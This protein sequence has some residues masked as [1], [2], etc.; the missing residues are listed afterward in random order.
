MQSIAGNEDTLMAFVSSSMKELVAERKAVK[1]A[2][3][4]IHVRAWLWEEP[5]GATASPDPIRQQYVDRLD[6]ADLYIG[7]FRKQCNQ[8]TLDEFVNARERKKPCFLYCSLP[9]ID[10]SRDPALAGL[11]KE[12][13][14]VEDGITVAYFGTLD[15]L[16]RQ[17]SRAVEDWR[18]KDAYGKRAQ[19]RDPFSWERLRALV[20]R[21][22]FDTLRTAAYRRK[23]NLLRYVRREATQQEVECFLHE[24]LGPLMFVNAE[25]GLGKTCFVR[26]LYRSIRKDEDCATLL[27]RGLGGGSGGEMR[28]HSQLCELVA[29]EFRIPKASQDEALEALDRWLWGRRR[30]LLVILDGVNEAQDPRAVFQGVVELVKRLT[31]IAVQEKRKTCLRLLVTSRP[32]AYHT[33]MN[34]DET[35]GQ[36]EGILRHAGEPDDFK[37]HDIGKLN[38][39]E[40]DEGLRR[41]G[42]GNARI[43]AHLREVLSD[44]LMLGY[45]GDTARDLRDVQD[46]QSPLDLIERVWKTQAASLEALCVGSD[47]HPMEQI[48]AVCE[49]LLEEVGDSIEPLWTPLERKLMVVDVLVFEEIP[50]GDKGAFRIR[51]RYDRMAHYL[52]AAKALLR[53]LD[54]GL[55]T[56]EDLV[57]KIVGI[58]I[59]GKERSDLILPD[60]VRSAIVTALVRL[61]DVGRATMAEQVVLGLLD[62]RPD[63]FAGSTAGVRGAVRIELEEMVYDALVESVRWHPQA[64][65]DLL[66]R[67]FTMNPL[68]PDSAT[69]SVFRRAAF[70]L[71][72][73][74]SDEGRGVDTL[75]EH[76]KSRL[77]HLGAE[78]LLTDGSGDPCVLLHALYTGGAQDTALEIL[79]LS[80]AKLKTGKRR[81]RPMHRLPCLVRVA[82]AMILI[83]PETG[84]ALPPNFEK[85]L[86]SLFREIPPWIV[87]LAGAAITEIAMTDNVMPVRADQWLSLVKTP[88]SRRMFRRTNLL[89]QIRDWSRKPG[90]RAATIH[91]AVQLIRASRNAFVAQLLT[92]AISCRLAYV[93]GTERQTLLNELA[94]E[95]GAVRA[96]RALDDP[97][98]GLL[99][100]SLSLVC[101]HLLVFD[102]HRLDDESIER[103]FDLMEAL[104][105]DVL[106]APPLLGRFRLTPGGASETSNIVG[107]FGRAAMAVGKPKRLRRL[108]EGLLAGTHDLRGDPD[109]AAFLFESLGTLGTLSPDPELALDCLHLLGNSLKYFDAVDA[110]FSDQCARE[111]MFKSLLQIRDLHPFEVEDYIKG[112]MG[113]KAHP[114]IEKIRAARAETRSSQAGILSRHMSW[115]F[116]RGVEKIV[117][118]H[119]LICRTISSDIVGVLEPHGLKTISVIEAIRLGRYAS[120]LDPL[121]ISVPQQA[122][123]KL[124][125]ALAS[126]GA[127]AVRAFLHLRSAG[128]SKTAS[129]RSTQ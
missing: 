76:D 13:G 18:A 23:F 67:W 36:L 106:L 72:L 89:M 101:Y 28:L 111:A 24:D 122:L 8:Y 48:S 32:R 62:P 52:L 45:Y 96:A 31:G 92:H 79:R 95:V 46:I 22:T 102:I 26:Y 109:F 57:A 56:G 121:K 59:R 29:T 68:Q 103:V 70:S 124:I 19:P 129:S 75:G 120:E 35:R 108:I 81:W 125:E 50:Q 15:D 64:V 105:K 90:T 43:G 91:E 74:A 40:L 83:F 118:Q 104:A 126:F 37:V 54:S 128:A 77:C 69:S 2:L 60:V 100:Y 6:E 88:E 61:F 47:A 110:T 16:A 44:P 113:D 86:R 55:R 93:A 82:T 27:L 117:L 49:R 25:S 20:A 98:L 94:S 107:T 30:K 17:V 4:A 12:L 39:A 112:R 14:S 42:L 119:P 53:G 73:S 38:P 9:R 71:L 5:D 78:A 33:Y 115:V 63:A 97:D 11:L 114:L 51:F 66:V 87:G 21:K 7:V 65:V 85:C 58:V 3:E 123:I 41:A 127:V 10:E 84:D 1:D 80:I 116:E 99:A 34:L